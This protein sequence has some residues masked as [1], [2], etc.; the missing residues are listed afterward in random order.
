MGVYEGR[1]HNETTAAVAV[2]GL[3]P[4]GITLQ[5]CHILYV[6]LFYV[7]TGG[8]L[9]KNNIAGIWCLNSTLRFCVKACGSNVNRRK[10]SQPRPHRPFTSKLW[11]LKQN[12]IQNFHQDKPPVGSKRLPVSVKRLEYDPCQERI[13]D[14]SDTIKQIGVGTDPGSEYSRFR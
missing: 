2:S 4:P 1:C 8:Q 10:C 9:R 5:L 14:F 11:H 12:A 6:V 7:A 3:A 13:G